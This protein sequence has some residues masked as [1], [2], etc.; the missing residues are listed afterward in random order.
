MA[1]AFAFLSGRVLA[2]LYVLILNAALHSIKLGVIV[3]LQIIRIRP[4]Y[5]F[6]NLLK[7]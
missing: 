6:S 1:G 3:N 5:H 7:L 4:I 2:D